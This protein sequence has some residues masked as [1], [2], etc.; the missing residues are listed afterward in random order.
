M[1]TESPLQPRCLGSGA[2]G[3]GVAGGGATWDHSPAEAG[4]GPN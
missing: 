2:A 4:I 1:R 3:D